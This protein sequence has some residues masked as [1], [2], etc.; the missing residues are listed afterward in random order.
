MQREAARRGEGEG[1]LID[2]A[3]LDQRARDQALE[4]LR[5]ALLHAGW[6]FLAEELE[7]KVGHGGP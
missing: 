1:A 3:A 5:G 6:D 4:V 2:E 7:Q